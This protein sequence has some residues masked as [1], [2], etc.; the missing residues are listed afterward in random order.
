MNATRS[1]RQLFVLSAI[2]F[3]PA[4]A[5]AQPDLR[6]LVAAAPLIFRGTNAGASESPTLPLPPPKGSIRVRVDEILRGAETIGDLTRQD[7]ILIAPNGST[8]RTAIYFVRP[9]EYGKLLV[10]E[11]LAEIDAPADLRALAADLAKAEQQNAD[12][13]LSERLAASEAVIVARV[14]DVRRLAKERGRPSEHDPDWA[15]AQLAIVRNLKGQPRITDCPGGAC[16]EVA[17]AQS[18]DIRWFRSPKLVPG[19]Q[20]IF[21]L[22]PMDPKLLREGEKPPALYVLVDPQDVRPLGDEQRLI[23]LI[24]AQR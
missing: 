24:R 5:S 18:D 13:A 23:R 12:A 14:R 7:V 4:A 3:L 11:E 21:L 1:L 16:V 10:A 6:Q 22:R 8:R 17:F 20:A 19:Q 2:A 9:V 15:L